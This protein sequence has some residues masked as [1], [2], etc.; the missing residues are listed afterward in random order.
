MK[1]LVNRKASHHISLKA[2][3]GMQCTAKD[4]R[5][6]VCKFQIIIPCAVFI[7]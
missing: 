5:T 2:V 1:L 7:F 3:K 4:K 6:R